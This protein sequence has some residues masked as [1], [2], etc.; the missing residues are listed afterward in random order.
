MTISM[1][2]FER[3]FNRV[4]RQSFEDAVVYTAYNDIQNYVLKDT[5]ALRRSLSVSVKD[6]NATLDW[7]IS[8]ADEAYNLNTKYPFYEPTTPNTYDHWVDA[9]ISDSGEQR[10]T[11]YFTQEVTR[12]MEE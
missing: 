2:D 5:G 9:W 1:D 10:F 3:K 12:R 6:F 8:Y 4:L 7:G 11:D